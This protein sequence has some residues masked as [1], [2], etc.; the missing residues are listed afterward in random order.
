[1]KKQIRMNLKEQTDFVKL[2]NE[3]A[4]EHSAYDVFCDFLTMSCYSIA[5]AV[6][7]KK[8][9]ESKYLEIIGK[10]KKNVQE[11]FPRLLGLVCLG[12]ERKFCD[13]LGEIY[14]DCGFG[15][16]RNGQFFTPY[17][18][19]LVCAESIVEKVKDNKIFTALEPS[20]GS[21]EMVIALAD[22][23]HKKGFNFQRYLYV[24]AQ[25]LSWNSVCMAFIQLSLL[26]IPATVVHCNSLTLETFGKFE[27]PMVGMTLIKERLS[28]Q[29]AVEGMK[30]HGNEES[31]TEN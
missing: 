10:Y 23:L 11:G 9:R 1:M 7:Y 6:H 27:T 30:N 5:N 31:D 18:V 8:E 2:L 19:A 25:D 20:C 12:L 28:L 15:D 26:G 3:M 21:G 4:Y 22:V 17:P 13:F 24:Q 29:N 14:M 16:D